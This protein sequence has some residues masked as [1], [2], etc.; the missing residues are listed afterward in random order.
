MGMRETRGNYVKKNIIWSTLLNGITT[1]YPFI[2]RTVFLYYL[3]NLYLGLN[4]LCTSVLYVLNAADFGMS[5][6]FVYRLYK[7]V[8]DNDLKTINALLNL[9]RKVYRGIGLVVFLSGLLILPFFDKFIKGEIPEDVN[10]YLVLFVYLFNAAISYVLFGYKELL[11]LA[12]QR[13]DLVDK[14]GSLSLIIMYSV[15]VYF[16]IQKSYYGYIFI[17]PICTALT[18]MIKA[19]VV[20]RK[21]PDCICKGK[22]KTEDRHKIFEDIFSIGI[23]KF[24]DISRSAFDS[25]VISSFLGLVILSNYQNYYTVLIVPIVFR[26]II[27][28]AIAPSMGNCIATESKK[29]V[30]D[31]YKVFIFCHI[32][33]SGFFSIVYGCLIQ[34][35]IRFWVGSEHLLST[36]FVFLIVIYFYVLGF[37]E[38]TK[39][40]R[41]AAGIWKRGRNYVAI[42]MG[43][44]IFLNIC[45]VYWIG[46]EGIILATIITVVFINIPVDYYALYRDYFNCEMKEIIAIYIKSIVWMI[47]VGTIVYVLCTTIPYNGAGGIILK[48]LSCTLPSIVLFL[49]FN[50]TSSEFKFLCKQF[51][52]KI[53]IYKKG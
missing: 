49:C 26:S 47:L 37:S 4:S 45:F 23:Y 30:Y 14:V 16:I 10:I 36:K 6:V 11:L 1:V 43:T 38:Q 19:V 21:Y 28:N 24:R 27:V 39:M 20:R 3:G 41:D 34:D 46:L 33:I 51:T 32:Y 7:P 52:R 50:Y 13:R 40:L 2:V 25:I 12:Y 9:Y 42:E 29:M 18:N 35:F 22:V 8:A 48:L 15:Q 31:I 44:N 17:M 53:S 5:N